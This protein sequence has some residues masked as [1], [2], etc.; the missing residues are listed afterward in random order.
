MVFPHE[1][2]KPV[3]PSEAEAARADFAP[4][5]QY[6]DALHAAD[7]RYVYNWDRLRGYSGIE[8]EAYFVFSGLS[9]GPE[10][11]SEWYAAALG[12][13]RFIE[14]ARPDALLVSGK[15]ALSLLP[16]SFGVSEKDTDFFGIPTVWL[17]E[18]GAYALYKYR[19]QD[20]HLIIPGDPGYLRW[21]LAGRTGRLPGS[22]VL[23]D[24]I[25]AGASK[26]HASWRTLKGIG[27]GDIRIAALASHRES[28][29]VFAGSTDPTFFAFMYNLQ[30]AES[31]AANPDKIRDFLTISRGDPRE[32]SELNALLSS[33]HAAYWQGIGMI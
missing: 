13:G 2:P 4:F 3:D 12:V 17:D 15:S 26:A 8:E 32:V 7:P 19:H 28:D 14:E 5:E 9:A 6:G 21:L 30:Q 23:V 24:D 1:F 22:L 27:V 20:E 29:L 18:Y 25:V 33:V 11:L 31:F 16:L 10:I